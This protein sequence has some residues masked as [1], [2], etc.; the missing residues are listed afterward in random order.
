MTTMRFTGRIIAGAAV[1]CVAM[2]AV[3]GRC[4]TT[5]PYQNSALAPEQRAADLVSRMTLEEKV[6]Q[7][8]N[9]SAAIP[10]L[11]VPAYDWWSEGLHGIARSGYATVFP[12]AIGNAATFDAPLV[13]QMANVIST[14]AR[15]K[16]NQAIRD[17]I[18][19]IYFGLTIW[20]PNINI[21]RDPRWG[22]GQE[23][24]GEDPF[25]TGRM[26]VAFVE[27][28]QGNDK[29]YLKTVATP[30]HYVVH[31]GPEPERHRF[32]VNPTPYDLEDTY[33]PAFRATV[34][35]G[36]ADSI[37]CA[38]NAVDGEPACANKMLLEQTLRKDWGFNG[39]IT[40]DCGAVDDFYSPHG[41]HYS[42]DAEHA[43]A[44]A[45]LAGT[46]TNCGD[47]YKA[48]VKA[49]K[50]GLIPESAL[51]T[52]V[53]RLFTARFRLGMFDPAGQN[54]YARIPM[55][56]DDS[57]EHRALALKVAR[58]SMVLLKNENGFLPLQ[59][60]VHTIAVIGP[61]AA[62][63][64]A[65]EGNYN[66]IP[67][68]P[69][70]PLDGIRAEFSD[71]KILYA[72][73]SAYVAE[74]P[75]PV[76]ETAF[77]PSTDSTQ[78]GLKAE[79]F[80]SAAMQGQPVLTRV[81]HQIDFDWDAASPAP[82]VPMKD[83]GVRWSGAISVPAAGDYPFS[84]NFTGCYP[85]RDAEAY[86][87]YLD[88]KPVA[89]FAA[90]A[91][92]NRGAATPAFTLHFEDTKPHAFRLE[93]T[94]HADLFGAGITLQWM[95]PADAEREQAVA[96]AREADAVVAFVGLSPN[97]EGEEMPIHVKGFLGGDRTDIQLPP[98]QQQ[99]LEAVAA[100][101][102][103][104]VVVL[105]NGSALAVNWAQQHAKALL[106][107]WYPGE[108]GGQAI[109]ETLDGKNNPA[110]RLPVTFYRSI[111]QIPAFE[112]YSMQ[113]RTY[114]YFHGDA[115]YKFGYGLSYTD[116][117]YSSLKLSSSR[118]EA[119]D[120]LRVEADVR[121]S[122]SLAGDEVVEVYVTPPQGAR[123]PLQEL[124]G[125]ARIY[126]EPEETQRV[127]FTLHPR[128]LSVVDAQGNRSVSPGQYSIFI[129]G[130]QPSP[131][132]GVLGT[133]SIHGSQPLPR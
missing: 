44:T 36:R 41:H 38:Y 123:A 99:L 11:G 103:P 94:H 22:R 72:Q 129:G 24:Y 121:N 33:L 77:H 122:G 34:T 50:G 7:T 113:G 105:M 126:L 63:L 45:M 21:F 13:G 56:E 35:D 57:P 110:G 23:T 70:L 107:A 65:I 75:V 112:N 125:F 116:F 9:S 115:L 130:N 87:V 29:H 47:T 132:S 85:C 58:E 54:A 92:E 16:Y 25:L 55:S 32:N 52:A 91:S 60:N 109:A 101:G 64:A 15:A 5:L 90:A 66:A 59:S 51:N 117:K 119:G 78:A 68:H 104:L 17:D 53:E 106:E 93:Y 37:M 46:D 100:T 96:A 62:S 131:S 49:V 120:D 111:D 114:R 43:A 1:L 108:A 98:V 8:M 124:E 27:G 31:S 30:K 102:K 6:S 19:S 12:Q 48:L 128:Q 4:Q 81:D 89:Q 69:V 127:S 95:P 86:K 73:G 82:G 118:I 88:G 83:F 10:R 14:E 67:S 42:P 80:A 61:N 76:P 18:H 71:A 40:S 97:L 39:Y 26:G 20:S 74:L 79:Y 84:V 3:S 2:G 28:L 133:F